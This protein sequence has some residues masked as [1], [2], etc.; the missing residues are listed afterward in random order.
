MYMKIVTTE[1]NICLVLPKINND[2]D[3]LI[4]KLCWIVIYRHV[5]K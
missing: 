5:I 2:S 3:F 4:L 1:A